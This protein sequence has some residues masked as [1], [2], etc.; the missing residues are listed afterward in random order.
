MRTFI[1]VLFAVLGILL[2]LPYHLYLRHLAKKNP[3]A[4]YMKAYKLVKGF[5]GGVMFLAGCKTTVIGKE[6]VPTDK[7]VLFVGNHRS[8]FDILSTHNCIGFPVGYMSKDEI[9]KIPLLHLYMDDI[10]C[11]YLNRTDIKKG[12][13]TIIQCSEIIKSGHSMVIF[14][15]GTRNKGE[16]LLPFKDGA[17]KIA[18]KAGCPIIPISICGTDDIMENNKHNMLHKHKVIIEFCDPID[19]TGLKPKERKAVLDTIPEIIQKTRLKNLPAATS[20]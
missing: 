18:Q 11:T 2:C 10:G 6:K 5:F 12:L 20:K 19:V 1:T 7:P 15:E 9:K 3:E 14:P 16:E 4:A 17:Y 8:Y 13:E